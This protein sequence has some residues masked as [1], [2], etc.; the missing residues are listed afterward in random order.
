[1]D[2]AKKYG[3]QMDVVEAWKKIIAEQESPMLSVAEGMYNIPAYSEPR[4]VVISPSKQLQVMQWGLIPRTAKPEDVARYNKENWFK[5]ARG[6]DIFHTWP[7]KLSITHRRCLIPSTG[8]FE[9]HYDEK[10][11]AQPYYIFIPTREVFNMAGV[12]D[13][14][15]I[16]GKG[17]EPGEGDNLDHP[18]F[19]KY[20][21]TFTQITTEANDL[22][23]KIHNG[24]NHPF[25][26]PVILKPE[27]EARWLDPNMTDSEEIKEFL[28]PYT[29]EPMEAYPVDK[30]FRFMNPYKEEVIKEV[31][32]QGKLEI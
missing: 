5:N 15:A 22:A 6:E 26:M 13:R 29:D 23:R 16:P 25:R 7:Y 18:D 27:D 20:L 9:F 21:Y 3:R 31:P 2:I 17:G 28:K 24:G 1:M 4:C 14:W 10:K 11:Q 12:W 32:E 8:Y 30:K 19:D